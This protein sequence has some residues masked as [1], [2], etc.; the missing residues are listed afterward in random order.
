M[1]GAEAPVEVEILR[2]GTTRSRAGPVVH[3]AL[4]QELAHARRRRAGSRFVPRV[5]A[6][7]ACRIVRPLVARGCE[8]VVRQAAGWPRGAARRSRARRA[9]G[10]TARRRARP[11]ASS[12]ARAARRSRSGGT[13]RAARSRPLRRGCSARGSAP[14]RREAE[15]SRR[16]RPS[17][18][19][20]AAARA[21]LAG[22]SSSSAGSVPASRP[23]AAERPRAREARAE[24]LAATLASTRVKIRSSAPAGTTV[25]PG[26]TPKPMRS[27]SSA[28]ASRSS[29]WR[30]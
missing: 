13:G 14:A 2:R 8:V 3:P 23:P 1:R 11:R 25:T 4:A 19:P 12:R 9:G 16:A 26:W 10:R 30:A 17:V 20:P 21:R 28:R 27:L 29:R 24:R 7:N 22:V 5:H 15:R 18:S 6:S